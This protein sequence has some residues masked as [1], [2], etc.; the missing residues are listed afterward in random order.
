MSEPGQIIGDIAAGALTAR[1]VEPSHGEAADGHTHERAC[2][3]C[4]TA[5]VGPHCH[6]CGQAARMGCK[7]R[8]FSHVDGQ[9]QEAGLAP[10]LQLLDRIG[11][12]HRLSLRIAHLYIHAAHRAILHDDSPDQVTLFGC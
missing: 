1:A 10:K 5:L 11:R 9:D 3:N 7:P 12:I 4:G 8:A 6:N 2:L